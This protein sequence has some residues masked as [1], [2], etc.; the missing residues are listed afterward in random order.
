MSARVLRATRAAA[1]IAGLGRRLPTLTLLAVLA[2]LPLIGPAG[3]ERAPAPPVWD[4]PFD[5]TG[6]DDG[7]PLQLSVLV[8][9]GQITLTWNQPQGQGIT[10]YAISRADDQAGP[11]SSLALVAHTNTVNMFHVIADP[12]PTQAHWYRIQALDADGNASA[13]DYATPAG[14]V[15]GPR[16]ILNQGGTTVASRF[17]TLKVVVSR[18]TTLE[19]AHGPGYANTL[20]AAAAAAGDTA[21]INFDAG[22]AAQG[23]SVRVRVVATDG[24]YASAPAFARARVDFTPDFT[25]QGGGNHVASRTVTLAI[26]PAGVTQMR[27]AA[28]EAALTGAAWVPGAATHTELLLGPGTG[29]QEIW[30]E[31]AGDFGYNSVSHI[32]VS[33]DLLTGA[34]FRLLVPENHV[35][36]SDSVSCVLTGKATLVRWSE[37]PNLAAAPWRA[38]ADTLAIQLSAAAGLKT[39]YLQMHNDWADSPIL[40]DYAVFVARGVEAAFVAPTDGATVQSGAVLQMRGTAFGGG[41][42]LTAVKVDPGD[43]IFVP[44]TGLESWTHL[45]SAPIV[46]ADTEVSLRVRAWAGTDSTT[47][48]IGVTVVP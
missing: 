24:T 16:V 31:F 42:A 43:G 46:L 12:T 44:A 6:P 7:D 15:L 26:P 23:D 30:G 20:T 18:G 38:F 21:V 41:A 45:W 19:I 11:W 17:V 35:V 10:E 36:T 2:L 1:N 33:P 22:T 5:P 28:S 13:V 39:I 37:G 4:N 9:D 8:A 32:T 34:T 27:F 29:A 25:L 48:V 14:V 40:T 3:C 47:S